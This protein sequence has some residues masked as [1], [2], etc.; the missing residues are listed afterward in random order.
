MELY[1]CAILILNLLLGAVGAYFVVT[2]VWGLRR[3]RPLGQFQPRYRFAV[4]IA[5]RNE[6]KVIGDLVRSL[7]A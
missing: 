7:L 6:E 2:A 1:Y 5:A 4:L 3:S